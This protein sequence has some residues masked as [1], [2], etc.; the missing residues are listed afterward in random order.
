MRDARASLL[1]ERAPRPPWGDGL[2]VGNIDAGGAGISRPAELAVRDHPVPGPGTGRGA[3]PPDERGRA[4]AMR[5]VCEG[6]SRSRRSRSTASAAGL[7]AD[8]NAG[9]DPAPSRFPQSRT[10]LLVLD[11]RRLRPVRRVEPARRLQLRRDLAGRRARSTWSST[12]RG[13]IPTRYAVRAYDVAPAGC[14]RSR[15]ST[16]ASRTSRWAA[17]RSRAATSP[18]GRWAYTLYDGAGRHPFVHALDTVGRTAACID[19]DAPHRP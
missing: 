3:H 11:A 16:R 19:L 2:P 13:A 9:P 14:C 8:G 1:S 6:T 4:G 17:T 12:C 5:R 7:S 10:Q 15:S 18:D